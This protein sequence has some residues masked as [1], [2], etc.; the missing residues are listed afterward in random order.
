[1]KFMRDEKGLIF[2]IVTGSFVDGPGVRTTIFLKG[3]PLRCVW[4]CN[5]EGQHASIELKVD[6]SKCN[7]CGKCI[8]VCPR[9]AIKLN[10][11]FSGE[12]CSVNRELC[13]NCGKCT[14]VCYTGCLDL[15]G[16]YVTTSEL[17]NLIAKGEEFYR[18]SGGGVTLGG[19]EPTF[20]PLFTYSILKKC[21]ENHIHVALD[22]CGYTTTELGFKLL[23]E[24]D[25]LLYDI[26]GM[27]R[28]EHIKNTTVSNKII[29]S[30]LKKRDEIGKPVIVRMP[31]VPGY[32]D[33]EQNL[34]L[35]ADFLSKLKC[36]ERV[37]ILPYHEYGIIKYKQLGREYKC[38]SKPPS[39]E[40]MKEIKSMLERYGLNVHIGG[41]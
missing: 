10:S 30:N 27:D 39:I 28:E 7:L 34:I 8:A 16:K 32:N 19:G 38:H 5:P 33:S 2:N 17:F 15:F 37:D 24:A 6:S 22:T 29:L 4:C 3:C 36:I 12:R 14:E 1:M 35:A 23:M 21:R 18:S 40:Y 41:V 20:Q 13:T 9:G 25:L 26:K 11:E 31:I